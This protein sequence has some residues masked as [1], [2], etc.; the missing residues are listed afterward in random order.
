MCFCVHFYVVYVYNMMILSIMYMC[1]ILR[2]GMHMYARLTYNLRTLFITDAYKDDDVDYAYF[3]LY[4]R[5]I[6]HFH[7]VLSRLN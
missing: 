4:H 2:M 7:H 5:E 1:M 3:K 6:I